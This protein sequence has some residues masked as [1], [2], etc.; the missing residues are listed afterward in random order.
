MKRYDSMNQKRKIG[1]VW[2]EDKPLFT[3]LPWSVQLPG[4]IHH[5]SSKAKALKFASAISIKEVQ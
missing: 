5:T 4:G 1:E 3:R 2:R